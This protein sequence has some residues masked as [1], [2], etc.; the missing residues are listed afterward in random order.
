MGLVIYCF[1]ASL[2]IIEPIIKVWFPDQTFSIPYFYGC[3]GVL[4]Y[5][6][7]FHHNRPWQFSLT[8]I[9][10]LA[11]LLYNLTDILKYNYLPIVVSV[12]AI[13][14]L[15]K[16][17][18]DKYKIAHILTGSG[19]LQTFIMFLQWSGILPTDSIFTITGSFDNPGPLGGY[20]AICF[21]A[22]IGNY[23][24][25]NRY[26]YIVCSL[27]LGVGL[28][29][30]DSRAAW[31][32]TLLALLY[33]GVKFL[34]FNK[35]WQIV[36]FTTLIGVFAALSL[37]IY[38]TDS[39]KG[40]LAI[41]RISTEMIKEHP[42]FGKGLTSF[43]G[44]YMKY[45][46]DYLNKHPEAEENNLLSNSGFAFN[47]F[48]HIL[49]EQ[50][51]VGLLLVSATLGL[52]ILRGIRQ[53]SPF[54]PYLIALTVFSFFSYPSEVLLL[55][56]LIAIVTGA[57]SDSKYIIAFRKYS[58]MQK[59]VMPILCAFIIVTTGWRWIE[60]IRLENALSSFLYRK[61]NK[62]LNY[63]SQYY[64]NIENN[65]DF[66][67]RYA[68]ILYM[69]G[70]YTS[71]IPA[72]K[73]AILLYPTTD[74]YCELGDI[75]QSLEQH[76]DAEQAYCHAIH[77]LPTRVYPHFCL[78]CL[79]KN[80]GQNKKAIDKAYDIMNLPPQKKNQHYVEIISQV[81]QYITNL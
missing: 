50:G 32:G 36:T 19:I 46:A 23:Q 68:R 9:V 69:K 41:W 14:L 3:T 31:L 30:S 81:K 61:D 52:L 43:R 74:K 11:L 73:Q 58:S 53:N 70:E 6:L 62:G 28:I 7:Q 15:S 34:H 78:F 25:T 29:L 79:Y 1:L 49:Y 77:L 13:Y 47:E 8:D 38:K 24:Y 59:V 17:L 33:M 57:L 40:R 5:G 39:A 22:C 37:T 10:L 60:N 56:I 54:F 66:L 55:S 64:S 72:M 20:L 12:S 21:I 42:V 65:T 44:D 45:Q 35:I 75:Y 71:A 80:I 18:P 48:L 51:I 76:E 16:S 27:M 63:L 26:L 67:L 2:F 4:L